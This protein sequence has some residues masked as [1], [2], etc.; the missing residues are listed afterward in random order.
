[1]DIDLFAAATQ[2]DWYPT[3]QHLRDHAPV[4]RIPGTNDFVLTRY[5]DIMHVLRHQR[6]FPTGASK[7]RSEA[8]QAVYDRGGWQRMTPLGTNPPVHRHYRALVDRFFTGE[9]LDRWRPFVE[10][11]ADELLATFEHDGH[12]EW[13]AQYAVPL[14]VRVITHVLGLPEAE[15][16]RLKRWSAAWI[17]PFV[18][19]LAPD[20]DVWVAEQVVEMYAF[21][22][23]QIAEKRRAPADDVITHLTR[24]SFTGDEHERP[25][26]DQ[27]IITIVDHLFVGGNETTTF[28]MTSAMW[29]MLREPGLYERL[30]AEPARVPDFVEEV[31]RLESPTQGLWRAV[32]EDTEVNGVKIPSG[33]TV[34]L[35]YAAGNR[36]ERMFECPAEIR[37]DRPNSG[38]HLAFT[39]GEHQCPGADLSRLEQVLTLQEVLHRLPE[40][41]LAP[42]RNDFTHVP[43]FTM[44]AL[45]ELHL[46]FTPVSDS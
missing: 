11:C 19:P 14:P 24:A 8:T 30:R 43:M 36:D 38:R 42:G 46:E 40:L 10:R 20:E 1:M 44:R 25:L 45:K 6:V 17:L 16:P 34:H 41:R 28:A 32:A 5:D 27:E 3:Y 12:V 23:E 31:L 22:A 29:I 15:I 13:N 33:S 35:R 39:L 9:G 21:L 37:L 2:E 7:R 26:T 4:Y 18:R